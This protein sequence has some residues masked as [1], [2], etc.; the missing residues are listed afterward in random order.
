MVEFS[1]LCGVEI[2]V[3][4]C[5]FVFIEMDQDKEMIR[6]AILKNSRYF[7]YYDEIY[8]NEIVRRMRKIT[9]IAGRTIMD[10]WDVAHH[11]FIV[12]EGKAVEKSE[13]CRIQV[14]L[15]SVQGEEAL[16]LKKLRTS[17]FEGKYLISLNQRLL[18]FVYTTRANKILIIFRKRTKI[19]PLIGNNITLN[20]ANMNGTYTHLYQVSNV[21]VAQNISILCRIILS[22]INFNEMHKFF[23][24]QILELFTIYFLC[25]YS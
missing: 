6:D 11:L 18:L 9:F 25:D 20:I 7:K 3:Y 17:T 21:R 23:A 13:R 16:L 19:T 22:H 5:A 10:K 4:K 2:V 8:L 24:M 1:C 12:T 15:R 14:S